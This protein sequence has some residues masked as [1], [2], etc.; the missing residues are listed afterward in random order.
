MIEIGLYGSATENE[1][2]QYTKKGASCATCEG[3]DIEAR[4]I[5]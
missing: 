1:V 3:S 2:D 4:A 5:S